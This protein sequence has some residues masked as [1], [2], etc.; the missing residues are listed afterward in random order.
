MKLFKMMFRGKVLKRGKPLYKQGMTGKHDKD[1][2]D[3]YRVLLLPQPQATEATDEIFWT[4]GPS[5]L[6]SYLDDP[7]VTDPYTG[8]MRLDRAP[9]H[10]AGEAYAEVSSMGVY[11]PT[12]SRADNAASVANHLSKLGM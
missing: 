11:D 2:K 5:Y 12:K 8:E 1:G 3:F 6:Y 10:R 9:A 4:T 7:D